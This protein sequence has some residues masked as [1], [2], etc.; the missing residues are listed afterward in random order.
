MKG[1]FHWGLVC[2]A[3][4]MFVACSKEQPAEAEKE[5][6]LIVLDNGA[7][8]EHIDG[9]YVVSVPDTRAARARYYRVDPKYL[10]TPNHVWVDTQW[11]TVLCP[12]GV[13]T[14]V[15]ENMGE[16][17]FLEVAEVGEELK[18]QDIFAV[19]DSVLMPWEVYMPWTG[20]V[21]SVNDELYDNPKLLNEDPYGAWIIQAHLADFRPEELM[22]AL[23]YA[24]YL[25][26]E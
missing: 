2:L 9:Y 25:A 23:E 15:T 19:L 1:F 21:R 20:M 4:S 5:Q 8:I 24:K 10:Y 16:I 3:L 13:T 18:E 26:I 17:T 22:S 6:T 11:S 7:T 14:W 12:I